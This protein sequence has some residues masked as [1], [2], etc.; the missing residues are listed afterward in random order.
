MRSVGSASLM[1]RTLT[2]LA[3]VARRLFVCVHAVKI[4][5]EPSPLPVAYAVLV[6]ETECT[7]WATEIRIVYSRPH[8]LGRTLFSTS[9]RI[10]FKWYHHSPFMRYSQFAYAKLGPAEGARRSERVCDRGRTHAHK[11]KAFTKKNR[12]HTLGKIT[13]THRHS[14]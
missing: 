9:S 1:W 13:S 5:V 11:S 7:R 4:H 10:R 8:C 6:A 12:T 2:S 3:R 14:E